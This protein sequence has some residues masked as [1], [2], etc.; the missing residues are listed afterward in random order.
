MDTSTNKTLAAANISE[1]KI[2]ASNRTFAQSWKETLA[3]KSNIMVKYSNNGGQN[4]TNASNVCPSGIDKRTGV[5][6][7][8]FW[9]LCIKPT[10]SGHKN[11]FLVENRTGRTPLRV[12]T[13]IS[14]NKNADSTILDFEVNAATGSVVATW[15]ETAPNINSTKLTNPNISNPAL[16]TKQYI[17][18]CY[19]GHFPSCQ[20]VR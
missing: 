3:N 14:V 9:V 7:L 12:L 18:Y 11:I 15:L 13:D 16:S 17:T 2:D 8:Q 1:W 20:R 4:Y 6:G 19:T 10:S 5:Y